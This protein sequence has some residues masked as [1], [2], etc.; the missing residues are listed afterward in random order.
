MSQY[1]QKNLILVLYVLYVY[2]AIFPGWH[3]ICIHLSSKRQPGFASD[4]SKIIHLRTETSGSAHMRCLCFLLS[5]ARCPERPE[6]KA[7]FEDQ[8]LMRDIKTT[9]STWLE[10]IESTSFPE[11][12]VQLN[13]P[14]F[15][16]SR[17]YVGTYPYFHTYNASIFNRNNIII[18]I[19]VNKH[20]L[21]ALKFTD[22]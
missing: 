21:R 11:R 19:L 4:L 15:L 1:A 17:S 22:Y 3:N 20:K 9:V 16:P 7:L 12:F 14:L 6:N 13:P 18:D 8:S 2:D 10:R 5:T